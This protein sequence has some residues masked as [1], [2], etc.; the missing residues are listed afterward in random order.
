MEGTSKVG[1]PKSNRPYRQNY[2]RVAAVEDMLE[3]LASQLNPN[4]PLKKI[5][6]EE[7]HDL[8][9]RETKKVI[10]KQMKTMTSGGK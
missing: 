9:L 10:N 2:I 5:L 3:R 1:R 8:R 7:L 6:F 4:S